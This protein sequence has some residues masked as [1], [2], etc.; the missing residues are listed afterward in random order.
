MSETRIGP[1]DLLL[2]FTDG[3]TEA[4][5]AAGEQFGEQRIS[6][7]LAT[8]RDAPL[9]EVADRVMDAVASWSGNGPADD[10]T[11]VAARMTSLL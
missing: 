10:Q 1:G 3:I 2:L 5:N 4:R 6:E 7:L 8:L 11:V 9:D